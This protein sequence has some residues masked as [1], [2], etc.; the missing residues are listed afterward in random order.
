MRL[1]NEE[2]ARGDHRRISLLC[3]DASPN[4]FLAN[5]IAGK[6]GGIA[7]FLTS[8]PQ[9]GDISTALD[10]IL[11]DWKSPVM[12]GM[13]LLADRPGLNSANRN[14]RALPDGSYY[15][16]MGEL[17]AGR[18]AWASGKVAGRIGDGI[19]FG[20]IDGSGRSSTTL[21]LKVGDNIDSLKPL[22]GAR[23]LLGL[24]FLIHARYS[25][26]DLRREL[27]AL[28]YDPEV[29]LKSNE[30]P[31]LYPENNDVNEV[32]ALRNFIVKESLNYGLPSS[33]TALIAVYHKAGKR[34]EA[35]ALVPNALPS[36]WDESFETMD[37]ACSPM[38]RQAPRAGASFDLASPRMKKSVLSDIRSR[39][40]CSIG[41]IEEIE[42]MDS[43]KEPRH[44][45]VVAF[46]ASPA[47]KNREAIL[48]DSA[49]SP[50][51]LKGADTIHRLKVTFTGG[52]PAFIDPGLSILIFVDDLAV[53]RAKVSLAD[54]VRQRGVRTL[55]I[56]IGGAAVKLVLS[57][58]A[59]AWAKSAPGLE[60][61]LG[62]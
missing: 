11:E 13:K 5:E 52:K 7:K 53:P 2:A 62:L 46:S 17:T 45:E 42:D 51:K 49:A 8:D 38:A 48:F 36:G 40:C 20:L 21:T 25:G 61:S 27:V 50:G 57:D 60:V 3:I 59:G 28:G 18:T 35:T 6:G 37:M 23:K 33:E 19:G 26:K 15:L 29:A 24:E 9:E 47:F 56:S 58:P 44:M 43:A 31:S 16:D 14:V 22:Y 4:S 30:K 54:L 41:I 39:K 55:N 1:V 32:E 12:A 34:V 10:S